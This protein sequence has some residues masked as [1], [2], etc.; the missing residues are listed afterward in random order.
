MFHQDFKEFLELLNKNDVEYLIVGG[1]AVSFHGYPRYT[2]DLD[3]W[4]NPT[5]ENAKKILKSLIEFGFQS[6]ELSEEDFIK[7][8]QVIQLGYPPVRIDIINTID[9]VDFNEAYDS[10]VVLEFDNMIINFISLEHLI[11]NKKAT[12]RARD[13]DD[14]ENLTQ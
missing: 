13:I 3:V 1:Y 11:K 14:I 10:K 2:G 9:S 4:I 8:N 12:G 7:E 6:S 5:K